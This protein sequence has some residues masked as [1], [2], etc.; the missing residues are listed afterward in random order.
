MLAELL[1]LIPSEVSVGGVYLP[2]ALLTGLL[3]LLG[4][5]LVGR[6]LN[7]LRWSRY[8]LSPPLAFLALWLLMSSLVG[9]FV[10]VP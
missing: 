1:A 3:G 4:A 8:V 5:T 10:I 9:L 2:P 7:R 6:L